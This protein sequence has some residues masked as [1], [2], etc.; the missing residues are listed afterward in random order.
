MK[1]WKVSTSS[2]RCVRI[3]G[4]SGLGGDVLEGMGW[5]RHEGLLSGTDLELSTSCEN[6]SQAM[7][8]D[9]NGEAIGDCCPLGNLANG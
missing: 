3:H 2:C 9:P 4:G 5:A 6:T 7:L 1:V 8:A